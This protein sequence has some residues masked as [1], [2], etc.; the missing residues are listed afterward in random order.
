LNF[1]IIY[2]KSYIFG[3]TVLLNSSYIAKNN[4]YI[5]PLLR[6]F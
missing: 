5:F 6:T 4:L 2:Y 3:G 1:R